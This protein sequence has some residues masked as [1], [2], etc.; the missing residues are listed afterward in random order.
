[1]KWEELTAPDF[2]IAVKECGI[3]ILPMG[4]IERHG[5]HLPLG[6]DMIN[7]INTCNLAAEME[8]AI[9]F[10]PFITDKSTKQNASG[11]P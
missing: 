3:F 7:V 2:K 5:N 8:S 10:S 9:V 11:V 1:M 4:V 6:T